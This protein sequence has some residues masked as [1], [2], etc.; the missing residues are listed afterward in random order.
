VNEIVT[1]IYQL[2]IPI[3]NNPLGN[4]NVYLVKGDDRHLLIDAGYGNIEAF[5]SLNDQL[6]E[7]GVDPADISQ[8]VVTHA[9]FDHYGLTDR[10]RQVSRAKIALHYL[11][12]NLL[13]QRQTNVVEFLRQTEQWFHAAGVPANELPTPPTA[14]AGTSSFATPPLP[15]IDLRSGDEISAANY[16]FQVIWTPGHSPGHICLYE[17]DKKLLFAGDHV[18]PVITP[19]ISLQPLSNTNPLADFINSLN[20]VK[21]LAVNLVLPAHEHIYTDLPKRVEEI[22]LH[23]ELRN[24]EILEAM[25]TESKTAYQISTQV[26]WMPTLGGVSFQD[27]APWD[28]RMAVSETLAHL[29][30]MRVDSRISQVNRDNIIY[31]QST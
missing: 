4:T 12:K 21:Q 18:L 10:L 15:D 9:H 26:T 22:I 1:G 23:H 31:Y 7:I 6:T 14:P 25:K 16:N 28:R 5:Q 30:A 2:Q 24:L 19:H 17:P 8:I 13:T 27:L 29:E 11:E 20:E 3:P